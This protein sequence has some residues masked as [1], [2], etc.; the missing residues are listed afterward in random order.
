[1][2]EKVIPGTSNHDTLGLKILMIRPMFGR[3]PKHGSAR[4]DQHTCLGSFEQHDREEARSC[5]I[6]FGQFRELVISTCRPSANAESRSRAQ[7]K[8]RGGRH[9]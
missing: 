1:M 7:S 5:E 9:S 6:F 3:P 4:T 8:K 2:T